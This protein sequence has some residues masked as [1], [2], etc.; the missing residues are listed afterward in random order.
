MTTLSIKSGCI[1]T[2]GPS[3]EELFDSLRLYNEHRYVVFELEPS[4]PSFHNWRVRLK[5]QIVEIGAEDGSGHS[6]CLSVYFKDDPEQN[7][8]LSSIGMNK[9]YYNNHSRKGSVI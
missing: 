7:I 4:H 3:R 8:K 5:G 1:I 2:G 6:W 9:L